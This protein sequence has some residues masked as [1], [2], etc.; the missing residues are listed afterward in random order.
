M[1][2][3][4][5]INDARADLADMQHVPDGGE[6]HNKAIEKAQ[7]L[8][9][10][11]KCVHCGWQWLKELGV[12]RLAATFA[13]LGDDFVIGPVGILQLSGRALSTADTD[14]NVSLEVLQSWIKMGDTMRS[15]FETVF[16]GTDED[17]LLLVQACCVAAVL[18]SPAKLK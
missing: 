4:Q 12:P 7:A 16:A 11:Q 1:I 18:L 2:K 14:F 8:K 15:L 10:A 9:I 13:S 6:G 5:Q 3:T 17:R